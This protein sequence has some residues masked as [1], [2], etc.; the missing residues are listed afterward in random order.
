MA[1][2]DQD[3]QDDLDDLVEEVRE[4]DSYNNDSDEDSQDV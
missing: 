2:G 1:Y 3:A 4:G